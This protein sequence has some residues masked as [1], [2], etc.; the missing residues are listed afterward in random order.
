MWLMAIVGAIKLVMSTKM[1][2]RSLFIEG[3]D[4]ADSNHFQLAV[5]SH[6]VLSL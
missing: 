6:F 4:A 1:L 5:I 2:A 3:A